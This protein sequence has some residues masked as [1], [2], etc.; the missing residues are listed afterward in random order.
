[1]SQINNKARSVEFV[2]KKKVAMNKYRKSMYMSN[3][4]ELKCTGKQRT[5]NFLSS[6]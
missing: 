1:M 6:Y 5:V 2:K 3:D 4:S